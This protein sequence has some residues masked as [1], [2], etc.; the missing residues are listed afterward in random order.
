MLSLQDQ[1][2]LKKHINLSNHKGCLTPQQ[3]EVIVKNN[4]FN[5][6]VPK[7][8]NGLELDLIS[9]LLIQ[10]QLASLDG[11]LGWTVT[12]C[13]G[14]NMFVGFL[15]PK[16]S[17]ELFS[18]RSVCFA[19]SGKIAGK[20]V[21]LDNGY[22]I[23]G[24]WDVVT[25]LEHCTVFTANCM[26]IKNGL[27]LRD[28]KGDVVYRSFFFYPDE[29]KTLKS[30]NTMGL[31]ATGSH[32]YSV[33]KIQVNQ[34][35]C[36][37]IDKHASFNSNPIYQIPFL[38]FAR[39]TLAVNI[40]GM[41]KNFIEKAKDYFLALPNNPYL[42]LHLE[43]VQKAQDQ[44][45]V[46]RQEFFELAALCWQATLKGESVSIELEQSVKEVC[47]KVVLIGRNQI[48][49]LVPYLGLEVCKTDSD[50]NRIYLDILTGSQHSLFIR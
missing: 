43:L 31:K 13:S 14:A 15:N 22:E 17:K 21:E 33:D 4:L 27:P 10:E 48:M 35:R 9:G 24:K 3:L 37:S 36:F 20:A 44:W 25:G 28:D 11:S 23:S 49:D 6:F 39:F 45:Q 26:I 1:E 16:V 30:W 32:G 34:N 42:E 7:V 8:Y 46:H 38:I 40:L 19:G 47:K 12:L 18:N 41:R 50:L 5:L 29:V 2:I